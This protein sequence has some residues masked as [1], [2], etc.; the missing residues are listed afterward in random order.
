[1]SQGNGSGHPRQVPG[2]AR[3]EV[4]QARRQ[5]ER[6][7]PGQ[8]ADEQDIQQQAPEEGGGQETGLLH[9][10]PVGRVALP[11][12][13]FIV[14]YHKTYHHHLMLQVTCKY[15]IRCILPIIKIRCVKIVQCTIK[16]FYSIVFHICT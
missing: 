16:C 1:M 9:R 7:V 6:E 13:M 2:A 12:P 10:A 5:E 8:Q 15:V 4:R 11:V 3:G 14:S